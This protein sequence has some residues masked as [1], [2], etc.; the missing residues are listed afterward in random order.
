MNSR[1]YQE[2]NSQFH[3]GDLVC[4]KN[5]LARKLCGIITEVYK[6]PD[7]TETGE[8]VKIYWCI[9]KEEIDISPLSYPP[10]RKNGWIAAGLLRGIGN[11]EVVS[12]K[13]EKFS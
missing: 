13:N 10:I 5:P 12:K 7:S 1:L 2:R 8:M 6:I 9:D 11:L 4:Y 3:I